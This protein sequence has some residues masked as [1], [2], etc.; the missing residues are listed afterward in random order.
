MKSEL[1][2]ILANPKVGQNGKIP[3]TPFDPNK[4][5]I[6]DFF[7]DILNLANASFLV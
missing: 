3:V 5:V 7:S 1:I 6:K 4:I 2:L